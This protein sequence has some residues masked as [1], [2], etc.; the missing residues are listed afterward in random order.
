MLQHY[1]SHSIYD[2]GSS[3]LQTTH[4]TYERY[5]SAH[6]RALHRLIRFSDS[7]SGTKLKVNADLPKAELAAGH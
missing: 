1:T 3:L 5:V 2:A 7:I 6:I 4:R